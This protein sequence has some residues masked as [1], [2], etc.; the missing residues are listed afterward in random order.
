ML[1]CV[2]YARTSYCCSGRIVYQGDEYKEEGLKITDVQAENFLRHV[3]ISY[4]R[5]MGQYFRKAGE[6]NVT[7]TISTPWLAPMTEIAR[8]RRVIVKEV[9]S[10]TYAGPGKCQNGM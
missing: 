6:I 4:S 10:C 7:Y 5:P 3:G 1:L 9:D 8:V 2:I